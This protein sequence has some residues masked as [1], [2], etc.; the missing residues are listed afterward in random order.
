MNIDMT[1]APW[2]VLEKDGSYA[3]KQ[4][5][6]IYAPGVADIFSEFHEAVDERDRRNAML[7]DLIRQLE[8][9][10]QPENDSPKGAQ[11]PWNGWLPI[12]TEKSDE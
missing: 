5:H 4:M 11:S 3:L 12:S 10:K 7:L 6:D 2:E 1:Y 8:E 9:L